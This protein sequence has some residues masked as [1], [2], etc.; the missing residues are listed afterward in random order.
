MKKLFTAAAAFCGIILCAGTTE[1]INGFQ[2]AAAPGK[3]PKTWNIVSN[4]AED[5]IEVLTVDSGVAVMLRSEKKNKAGVYSKAIPAAAGDK[6]KIAAK[7]YGSGKMVFAIFQYGIGRGTT[8]QK[9]VIATSEKG[10]DVV[11]EFVVADTPKRKTGII[12]IAFIT[13]K[14]NLAAVHAPKAWLT[15]ASAVRK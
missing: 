14:G 3:A 12:R 1:V 2:A 8:T 5:G 9:K 15:K 4:S 10:S 7:V 13:E 6:I 11:V